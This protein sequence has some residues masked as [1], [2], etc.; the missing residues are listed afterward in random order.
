M[1]PRESSFF[2]PRPYEIYKQDKGA[3]SEITSV[4]LKPQF[5]LD[6]KQSIYIIFK[7]PTNKRK[8]IIADAHVL[9]YV[10][11]DNNLMFS[12]SLVSMLRH[13]ARAGLLKQL[14]VIKLLTAYN[15]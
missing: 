11:C 6:L 5:Y 13:H 1:P 3:L 2:T 10:L 14:E 8:K 15:R 7:R 9:R 12:S 4:F